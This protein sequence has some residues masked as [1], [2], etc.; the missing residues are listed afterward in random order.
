MTLTVEINGRN[1]DNFNSIT[2]NTNI[3]E[4]SSQFSCD[5]ASGD[6]QE[7]Y[8]MQPGDTVRV[9][10]DGGRVVFTGYCEVIGVSYSAGEHVISAT[11][12]SKTADVV[13]STLEPFTL[14]A[15]IQFE[16]IARQVIEQIGADVQVI[17]RAGTIEQ[18]EAQ[19]L[20]KVEDG[21]NAF[22]LLD[23]YARKRQILISDDADGNLVL[24]RNE[25]QQSDFQ[26]VNRLAPN[27]DDNNIIKANLQIDLT[28]RYSS[29]VVKAQQSIVGLNAI[30]NDPGAGEI[31]SQNGYAQDDDAVTTGRQ[32]VIVAEN[33]GSSQDCA[34]RADWEANV[35]V[36]RSMRY[37]ATVTGSD[38]WQVNTLVNVQDEF[39]GIARDLLVE[40]VTFSYDAS[41]SG[42]SLTELRLVAADAYKVEGARPVVPKPGQTGS[43]IFNVE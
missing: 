29:Y 37:V 10:A 42:G 22:D 17:N 43:D 4:A 24:L 38:D 2:V 33:S 3:D 25:G 32:L 19:D 13:V 20:I 39:C 16:A 23:Q 21:Q 5:M 41:E 36:A 27:G 6:T 14:N 12:R 35:R 34:R 40:G 11:G 26:L 7:P 18:F 9:I 15:P 28:Q 31:A 30:F 8:P 1:F